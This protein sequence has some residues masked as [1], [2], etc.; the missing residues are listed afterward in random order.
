MHADGRE[1]AKH[2][3][4]IAICLFIVLPILFMLSVSIKSLPQVLYQLFAVRGPFYFSNYMGAWHAVAPFIKNSLIMASASAALAIITASLAG[5]AFAK[6]RFPGRDVLFWV[7]FVK[8][9]L[10]G[11]LNLI[12]SFVLAWHLGL[13]NTYW[14]VILFAI[15]AAQPFWVVVM[16]TFIRQIPQ[17]LF[18]AARM[19]GAAELQTFW[20]VVAP[21]LRPMLMLMGINVFIAVWNDYVWPLVTISSHS[22]LPIGVGLANLNAIDASYGAYGP[23]MAGYAISMAPLILVFIIGARQFIEG[24]SSGAVKL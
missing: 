8:M 16:R 10:P 22:M 15:S 12:P 17:E 24:M 13:L 2:A 9:L 18:E 19:D 11:V 21:L 20:L 14:V 1:F 6:L 23:L 5:Y 4:L 7:I 3:V